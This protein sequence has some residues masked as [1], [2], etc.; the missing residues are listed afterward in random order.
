MLGMNQN[1]TDMYSIYVKTKEFEKARY[2]IRME[3][4]L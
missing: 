4:L 1:A 3:D 2:L